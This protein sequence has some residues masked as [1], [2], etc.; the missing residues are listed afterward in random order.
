MGNERRVMMMM[1]EGVN[2]P[3]SQRCVQEAKPW[4]SGSW[5]ANE[6]GSAAAS[7]KN[8]CWLGD[9]AV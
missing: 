5:L 3:R 2:S 1:V 7:S 6:G 4:A 8:R 9:R